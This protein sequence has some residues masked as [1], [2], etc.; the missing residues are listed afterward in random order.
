MDARKRCNTDKALDVKK[1]RLVPREVPAGNQRDDVKNE[2]F[3]Q[4]LGRDTSGAGKK[5]SRAATNPC[6]SCAERDRTDRGSV[7]KDGAVQMDGA[8]PSGIQ[9]L[10][11]V[12]ATTGGNA[13]TLCGTSVLG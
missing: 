1:R 9:S 8:D 11:G 6:G 2:R 3:M 10:C 12:D 5:G 7:S 4:I 13:G